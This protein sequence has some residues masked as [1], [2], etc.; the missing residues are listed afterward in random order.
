MATTL[1]FVLLGD[2]R[3]GAAFNRFAQ[4]VDKANRSVDKNRASLRQQDNA[5]VAASKSLG[6]LTGTVSG[7]GAVN[8]IASKKTSMFA[9]GLAALDI[10][11]GVGEAGISALIGTTLSLAAAYTSAAAGAGAYGLAVKPLLTQV[12]ALSKLQASAATGS[13]T[14]QKQLNA[15]L[16]TT[17]PE[18][19]KFTASVKSANTAYKSWADRLAT[20]V[21][22]PLNRALGIVRPVLRAITPLVTEASSAFDDLITEL[23]KKIQGG[24][25][26]RVVTVLL[27]HVRPVIEDLG[28]SIANIGAGLWG[29]LKAFL[30]FSDQV[31]HGVLDL[32]AKFKRWGETLSGHSG[33]QA[34]IEMWKQNWPLMK[35][36]L[37][38]LVKILRNVVSD[39]AGLATPANSRALW[40]IANPLLA[41]AL[42]LS[43]S[44][45]LVDALLYLTVIGKGAGQIKSVWSSMTTAWNSVTKGLSIVSGGKLNLGMQ[46]AGDT[47]LT[48]AQ[49][50]QKAADT[51]AG[52]SGAAGK[53]G[54]AAAGAEGTAGG[55]LAGLIS[56]A[57][58]YGAG[59]A[60][61]AAMA[62]GL[63][64]RFREDMKAGLKGWARDIPNLAS[65]ATGWLSTAASGMADL[66]TAK[67]GGRASTYFTRLGAKIQGWVGN[68]TTTLAAK[69]MDLQVGLGNGLIA[70]WAAVAHWFSGMTGRVTGFFKGAAGWL[71]SAGRNVISGLSTGVHALWNNT[72]APWFS[73]M[74]GRHQ[75]FF[76]GDLNWLVVSGRNVISGLSTGIHAVWNNTVAPWLNGMPGRVEGYLR[77]ALNWL[78]TGGRNVI[79]GLLNGFESVWKSVV[80]W[81][82]GLP[83]KILK[84]L[85]IA[86]PPPWA[87]SAGHDVM[88]GILQGL[89]GHKGV[90]AFIKGKVAGIAAQATAGLYPFGPPG[91]GSLVSYA[92]KLLKLYGWAS[93][94]GAFNAL[95]MS[96]AGWN[97]H[98]TNPSSGAYGLAQA[99]PPSKYASAGADWRTSGYTQLR[100]MMAYI[101]ARYGSP[102]A[103]WAFHLAH[104]WYGHG[105]PITEP[106]AGIGLRTGQTYGFGEAGGEQVS[107]QADMQA[108][109]RLLAV[110]IGEIR[111]LQSVTAA[112]AAATADGV[113]AVIN[114][115][116]RRA[117]LSR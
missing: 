87:I 88:E 90:E 93:Q 76:R 34:L 4:Q 5:A 7:F 66:L 113:G 74:P 30:P 70:G 79:W 55:G 17:P 41:L 15:M 19:V 80:S 94:F 52:A 21:L 39:M 62:A 64:Y 60:G 35:T 77:G 109:V 103:A 106:I 107:S 8:D 86:S 38:D 24:G 98:A 108:M 56:K 43:S 31:S 36:G 111:K 12:S 71:V 114:G 51:M 48:A 59:I 53:A 58:F 3:A 49:A 1:R 89:A 2:D 85:G 26:E 23:A 91:S 95:E 68:V 10:A 6:G 78:V 63:W 29:V 37:T 69:G 100:W 92:K 99:L 97:V 45:A 46:T 16:K 47:M 101:K 40:Q 9:K 116:A 115:T 44:P 18:I 50:M 84:A 42:R 110:L 32:T 83:S 20:P 54:S 65:G 13:K 73:G 57:Q 22:A 28:H 11:T 104:N 72:V 112:S 61:G 33:F 75:A 117:A 25:L 102:A 27:P 82:G 81:L 105:G 67:F 14:A 96:E